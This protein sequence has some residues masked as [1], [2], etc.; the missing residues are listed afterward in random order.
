MG[1]VAINAVEIDP[2]DG[3]AAVLRE[4]LQALLQT[5]QHSCDCAAYRLTCGSDPGGTWSLTGYWYSTERMQAHFTLPCLAELFEL[6]AQRLV[7]GLR[8]RTFSADDPHSFAVV[9]GQ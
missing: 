2:A 7:K 8:F 3:S 9:Q 4:R 1:I 6:T 5:L